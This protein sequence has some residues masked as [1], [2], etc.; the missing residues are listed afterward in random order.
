MFFQSGDSEVSNEDRLG[1]E[2]FREGFGQM[3][4]D[5]TGAGDQRLPCFAD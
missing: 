4:V 1:A 3:G 5:E 2:G